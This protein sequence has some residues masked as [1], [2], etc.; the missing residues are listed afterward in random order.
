MRLFESALI[1]AEISSAIDGK[2]AK[3]VYR[4]FASLMELKLYKQVPTMLRAIH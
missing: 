3:G 1:Y 4:K 2:Y